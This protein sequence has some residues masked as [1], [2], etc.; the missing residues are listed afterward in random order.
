MPEM[1]GITT[2]KKI[3]EIDRTAVVVMC[4]ALGQQAQVNECIELGA[5]DAVFKPCI[6]KRLLETLKKVLTGHSLLLLMQEAAHCFC[7]ADQ[8]QVTSAEA[9]PLT[10]KIF[11]EELVQRVFSK[12]KSGY[13]RQYKTAP[14][15]P[16]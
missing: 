9:V 15:Y 16:Q 1:D 8:L 3:L 10:V 14:E 7:E 12:R 6:S 4:A 11:S 13:P 2:L 5:K